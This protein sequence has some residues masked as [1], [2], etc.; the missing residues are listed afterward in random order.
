MAFYGKV[1]VLHSTSNLTRSF[2]FEEVFSFN[3]NVN[4][5]QV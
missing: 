2:F 3:R 1:Q 4:L 5:S